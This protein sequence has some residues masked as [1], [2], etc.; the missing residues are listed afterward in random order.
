MFKDKS[1]SNKDK[2]K[3][4]SL[5]TLFNRIK[6]SRDSIISLYYNIL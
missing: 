5:K 6:D 3:K 2:D 1:Y 4:A